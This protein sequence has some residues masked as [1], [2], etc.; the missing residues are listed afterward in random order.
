MNYADR[1]VIKL[2][3]SLG[4]ILPRLSY[5]Y[6][7]VLSRFKLLRMDSRSLAPKHGLA[8]FDLDSNPVT[9][10]IFEFLEL[11]QHELEAMGCKTASF[12]VLP[13]SRSFLRAT[14][15]TPYRKIIGEFHT[16]WRLW[17][18]VYQAVAFYPF[19]SGVNILSSRNEF[20]LSHVRGPL[21]PI[22]YYPLGM[23]NLD[24]DALYIK[25]LKSP[26]QLIGIKVP[27]MALANLESY[28]VSFKIRKEKLITVTLRSHPYDEAR[29]SNL[30][31]WE[32][33]AA[34][35]STMDYYLIVVPD[36]DTYFEGALVGYPALLRRVDSVFCWNI[37]LRAAL[38]QIA[39][40][41]FFVNNGPAI[42]ATFNHLSKYV[43]MNFLAPGSV[44]TNQNIQRRLGHLD[45]PDRLPW[46]APHQSVFHGPES[47]ESLQTA[48]FQRFGKPT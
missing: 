38:Y 39:A 12:V 5:K 27:H 21:F 41:S 44:V 4:A 48:F 16:E 46:S 8:V 1:L 17:N 32:E 30:K 23:R 25:Y 34:W 24:V 20:S 7:R 26:E 2:R 40:C 22:G 11:A 13:N 29:N 47:F 3:Y 10:N 18:L 36:Q 6:R 15:D 31:A 19:F 9:Y 28:I 43:V 42:L 14:Q 33:F 45:Y 35:V 37:F